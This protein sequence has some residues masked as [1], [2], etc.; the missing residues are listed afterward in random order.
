VA[1]SPLTYAERT[2]SVTMSGGVSTFPEDGN[3][4]DEVFV[5]ADQRLYAAKHGGRNR[6]AAPPGVLLTEPA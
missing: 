6:I 4:W 3:E 1:E 2:I 5:A